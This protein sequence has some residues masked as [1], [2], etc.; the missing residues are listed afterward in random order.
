MHMSSPS[1]PSSFSTFFAKGQYET[2]EEML[3]V[4]EKSQKLTIGIPKETTLQENRVAIVPNSIRIL[5]GYGHDVLVES[6]AGKMS[7]FT[8]QD[9]AEAEAEITKDR[10]KVFESHILIKTQP[11][12]L[13]E[14]DLMQVGQTLISPLPLPIISKDYVLKLQAKKICAVA[15]E[16]IQAED[17]SYPIVRMMSEIAGMVAM[18]AGADLLT[19]AS[20]GRGVLLGGISGVPPAKV[21]ILGAGVVGE[22]A[23]RTALGLGAS[24]RIFDNDVYKIMRLQNQIGR[25]LHTSSLNPVYLGYQLLS[26]DVVIGAIHSKNGRS[27]IIVTEEMVSKMK[28]GAV[29]IDVSIDQGGC[30]ETSEVTTIKNPTFI[31]HGVIHYC[32]PNIASNVSRTASISISNIITPIILQFSNAKNIARLLYD[33][34][35]IRNGVYLYN[36]KLTNE[37]LSRRYEM[38]YT[39]LNLVLTSEL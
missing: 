31:K 16:Y 19:K 9:Y 28:P 8:D 22:H 14:I 6:G 33:N 35:G 2:Q 34:P 24:V 25:P 38:K 11:P 12:T 17:R 7:S 20:G 18:L 4:S 26:A 5:K 37:Y 21:V 39:D 30:F 1:K 15:M 36:G 23:V 29:I 32:V 3:E 10:K 27:P 13:E